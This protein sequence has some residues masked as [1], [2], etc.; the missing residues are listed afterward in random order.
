MNVRMMRSFTRVDGAV[1]AVLPPLAPYQR[2]TC[3][4]CDECRSNE[5]WDRVFARFEVKEEDNWPTKGMF[6]ST[7][8]GW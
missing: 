7:L 4:S 2:C 8:R 6:Q 3:G 1:N 5:R